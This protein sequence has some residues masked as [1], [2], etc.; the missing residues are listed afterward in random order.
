MSE[1]L[2]SNETSAINT[3]SS[4]STTILDCDD[5]WNAFMNNDY[6]DTIIS[7]EKD[8]LDIANIPKCS[9]IYISTKTKISY[10]NKPINLKDTFWKIPVM[11]YHNA[12][13]GVI[14]KQIKYSFENKEEVKSVEELIKKETYV[15]QQS[16]SKIDNPDGK[17]KFKD[18]RK[19][20][21]GICKKDILSYRSKKKSAF[22]NCY[23]LILRLKYNGE[24]RES[25]VKVFNTGKLE[26]PGIQTDEFLKIVLNT[27][28]QILNDSCNLDI[29]YITDKSETVL[30]NSNFSSNYYIDREKLVDILKNKYKL[31]TTYDP[32]SYPGIMSKFY[33]IIN[34]VE[35][36]GMEPSQDDKKALI[37]QKQI[38][39]VSFMIFRTGSVLIVGKCEDNELMEIYEFLKEVLYNE[40]VN[41]CQQQ[42][43]GFDIKKKNPV[44]KKVRRKTIIIH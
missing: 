20:S 42:V 36:N 15:N 7:E 11:P 22:Y 27:V 17:I 30:I 3:L 31:N 4:N 41:I 33:Y 44:K 10:L 8:T 39:E 32:C 2:D 19:L 23:V 6:E 14:K 34:R 13:N 9:D 40:Y 21:I 1:T 43:M 25:N 24:F 16:I 38:K 28:V 5:A 18:V 37:E 35:Q 12:Q 26:I 29:D